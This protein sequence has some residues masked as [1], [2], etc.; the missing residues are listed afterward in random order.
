[1]RKFLLGDFYEGDRVILA[2]GRDAIVVGLEDSDNL[3]VKMPD[4]Q[5][6][7][8]MVREIIGRESPSPA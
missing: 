3:R 6:V 2:D 1:M 8:L 5:E 4:G 7:V